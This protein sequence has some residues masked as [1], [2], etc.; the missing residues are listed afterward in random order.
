[1]IAIKPKLNDMKVRKLYHLL[2]LPFFL[3]LCSLITITIICV[4]IKRTKTKKN[5]FLLRKIL[6]LLLIIMKKNIHIF[7]CAIFQFLCFIF[8]PYCMRKFN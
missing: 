8:L 1:M 3:F 2:Y 4:G 7:I 6:G 5:L